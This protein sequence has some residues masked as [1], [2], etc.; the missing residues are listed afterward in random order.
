[1]NLVNL[2]GEFIF[3]SL[4]LTN[5]IRYSD[6]EEIEERNCEVLTNTLE[7]ITCPDIIGAL[8]PLPAEFLEGLLEYMEGPYFCGIWCLLMR[9][10]RK[11]AVERPKGTCTGNSQIGFEKLM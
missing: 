10:V 11:I 2:H 6:I 8:S 9:Y 5:A 1:M 3:Y 4:Y 7:L